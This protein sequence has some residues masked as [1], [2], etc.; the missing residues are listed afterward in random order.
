MAIWAGIL[1][2]TNFRFNATW[3]KQRWV[4][5]PDQTG[6]NGWHMA[7]G[8][9]FLAAD[10]DGDNQKEIIAISNSGNWIGILREQNAK[11]VT[12]WIKHDWVNHPGRDGDNGWNLGHGDRFLVADV[13]GDGRDELI[14]INKSAS[15][16]GVLQESNGTLVAKWVGRGRINRQGGSA[17]TA[18][19][20]NSWD[21]LHVGDIDGDS[22]EE[23]VI[24]S[25]DGKRMGGVSWNGRRLIL[26]WMMSNSIPGASGVPD[27]TWTLNYG[28]KLIVADVDGDGKDEIVI[29]NRDASSKEIAILAEHNDQI[30]MRWRGDSIPNA[31]PNN[32]GW[33]LDPADRFIAADINGDGKK[34]L[35]VRCRMGTTV[36][37]I[38]PK[39]KGLALSWRQENWINRSG[40]SPNSGWHLSGGDSLLVADV[41]GDGKEEIVVVNSNGQWIGVWGE[42][43]GNLS[44][45]WIKHDWVTYPNHPGRNG[46]NLRDGDRFIAGDFDGDG[47]EELVVLSRAHHASIN[48]S[49]RALLVSGHLVQDDTDPHIQMW[50]EFT[51]GAG[52][53][54][55][56]HFLQ[57]KYAIFRSI[58]GE[59]SSKQRLMQEIRDLLEEPDIRAV[60]VITMFH[61]A[62]TTIALVDGTYW[63]FELR[64]D[65][66]QMDRRYKLRMLYSTTCHG[67]SH[68]DE[69]VQ[70]GFEAASGARGMNVSGW[71]EVPTF[72][73]LWG[74][75]ATFQHA[76]NEADNDDIREA[77]EAVAPT[78]SGATPDSEKLIVGNGRITI[79]AAP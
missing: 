39:G 10:I 55:I 42:E 54:T 41:N 69:F 27:N 74:D 13:N 71:Y 73:R 26:D 64:N 47:R 11:L 75:G 58:V 37:V 70:G 21:E 62:P 44:L 45:K 25:P 46:W 15:W 61:G 49:Q 3:V 18:W 40:R 22:S 5:H 77:T 28:D 34:E 4:N 16:I 68:A 6:S 30:L 23:L 31:E 67:F 7:D 63:T 24:I 2:T 19:N 59:S 56:A 8:D 33:S 12:T 72:T 65:L 51:E 1:D 14:V 53:A 79:R 29:A 66:L 20:L 60:D 17:R 43:S 9:R 78:S 50:R 35:I 48:K 52:Q 76:L 32:P 36:G 38:V 57:D